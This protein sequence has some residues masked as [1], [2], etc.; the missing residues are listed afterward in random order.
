MTIKRNA[1][2]VARRQ[3]KLTEIQE[4]FNRIIK[5][6]QGIPNPQTDKIFNMWEVNKE[7]FI[8]AFDGLIYTHPNKVQFELD[9]EAKEDRIISLKEYFIDKGYWELSKFLMKE[10]KGFYDNKVIEKYET[11]QGKIIPK[12]MKLV[13]A[14]KFFVEDNPTLLDEFQTRASTI[15]QD[16]KVEGYLCFSV[17]PLDFLSSS[18]NTHNWHTCHSLNGAYRAGN[19]SYMCDESTFICYLRS[20]KDAVLPGFPPELKWNNKKWRMLIHV[21]KEHN[22]MFAGRQY[23]FGNPAALNLIVQIINK[24][25]PVVCGKWTNW[26]NHYYTKDYIDDIPILFNTKYLPLRKPTPLQ[27]IVRDSRTKLHYNDVLYSN[28]YDYPYYSCTAQLEPAWS[29]RNWV[30]WMP[31]EV[32]RVGVDI[33]CLH[34]GKK[35]IETSECT[36]RCFDCEL[37]HGTE[38]NEMFGVCACCGARIFFDD[39]YY[40]EYNSK[41]YCHDCERDRLRTCDYCDDY[42]DIEDLKIG[43]D[44]EYICDYCLEH[45]KEELSE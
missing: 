27:D 3:K 45:I 37:E 28:V 21:N 15:I 5:Y 17:H 35:E 33:N 32:I 42:L 1:Q 8:K 18:E 16:D 26:Q 7:H 31:D 13:K 25:F 12:N 39:A 10:K 22:L 19:L 36:M 40:S 34:C 43:E 20:D 44:G 4:Q 6:S 29:P 11:K 41:H 24:L 38:C 2:I 9:E 30:N 23:P 14:F